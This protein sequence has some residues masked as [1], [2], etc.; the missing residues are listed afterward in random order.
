MVTKKMEQLVSTFKE[1]MW[2]SASLL[3]KTRNQTKPKQM[4]VCVQNENG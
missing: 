1:D 4:G 2:N 3:K